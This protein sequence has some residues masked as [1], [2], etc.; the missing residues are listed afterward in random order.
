MQVIP[1]INAQSFEEAKDFIKKAS[2]FADW[3]HVDVG[4]GIFTPNVTWGNPADWSSI[5]GQLS[6]VKV[7]VHLMIESPDQVIL[8]WFEAGANRVIVH[9][10]SMED[11]DSLIQLGKNFNAELGLAISP[12]TD[13]KELNVYFNKV[14]FYQILAVAPGKIG[15]EFKEP[16]LDKIKVLRVQAPDAIIEVDGGINPET[17][18]LVKEAGANIIVSAKYIWGATNPEKAF[19]DLSQV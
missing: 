17:A 12:D 3:V 9:V 16:I 11:A 19:L 2:E 10:E 15:Q 14:N 6:N 18:R 8:P 1:S 5:K 7:E 13:I 4:D